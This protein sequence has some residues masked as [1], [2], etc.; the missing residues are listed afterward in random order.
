M[1]VESK[2]RVYDYVIVPWIQSLS[3]PLVWQRTVHYINF[4]KLSVSAGLDNPLILGLFLNFGVAW[5]PF[6]DYTYVSDSKHSPYS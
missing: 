6:A 5:L 1:A 2:E 3:L 4:H